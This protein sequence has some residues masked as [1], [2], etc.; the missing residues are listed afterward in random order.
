MDFFEVEEH[1][2]L[3]LEREER[4]CFYTLKE[5]DDRNFVID[6]VV[7]RPEGT[8]GTETSSHVRAR[9]TTRKDQWMPPTSFSAC[10]TTT[11]YWTST[12]SETVST[13]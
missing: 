1:R 8:T 4:R 5:L 13:R 10:I 3:I 12:S 2:L 7:S 11:E 6:H 9:Q